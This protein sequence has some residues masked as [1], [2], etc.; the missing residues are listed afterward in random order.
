MKFHTYPRLKKDLIFT[1]ALIIVWVIIR[2]SS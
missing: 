2:V 1:I